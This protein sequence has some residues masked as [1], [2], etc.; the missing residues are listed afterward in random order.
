MAANVLACVL[1][2]AG[3]ASAQE[4]GEDL[5]KQLTTAT[6]H[7]RIALLAE[8]TD[9]YRFK[10]PDKAIAFGTEALELLEVSPNPQLEVDTLNELAWAH[11]VH[12]AYDVALEHVGRAQTLASN[13]SYQMGL[14]R[15]LNNTGVIYW[16][17]GEYDLSLEFYQQSLSIHEALED[18]HGIGASLNNIG[19]IY[20]DLG[21]FDRSLDSY[22]RSLRIK[23]EIGDSLGQANTIPNVAALYLAMGN[24]DLALS[25]DFAQQIVESDL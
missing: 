8:L 11:M 25:Q 24:T 1:I 22:I 3:T 16:Y 2:H 17:L 5:E 4:S 21:H 9:T 20:K 23:E 15:A 19:L 14:A 18:K 6:G 12:G 7:E 10:A 13:A